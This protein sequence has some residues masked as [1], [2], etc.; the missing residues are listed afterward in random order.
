MNN[1]YILPLL[2]VMNIFMGIFIAYE[3][4]NIPVPVIKLIR[5]DD[6]DNC[7]VKQENVAPPTIRRPPTIVPREEQPESKK[8]SLKE[9]DDSEPKT[10]Y[11]K[12]VA[13]PAPIAQ[14]KPVQVNP[15]PTSQVD[16]TKVK[17]FAYYASNID[18]AKLLQSDYGLFIV[19]EANA[20]G[21]LWEKP[22]VDRMKSNGKIILADI[23]VTYAESQRW[24][25]DKSWSTKKPS[26]L[27][28]EYNKGQYFVNEWWSEEWWKITQGIIDKALE[29]GYNGI[30]LSGIDSYIELGGAKSL[31]DKMVD[32]V[33]AISE[34]AKG[35]NP[36]F[37]IVPK[38]AELLGRIPT[39]A[40]AID[41]MVK[42]DLVYSVVSN[43]STGPKNGYNQI[44]KSTG[45]LAE[46]KKFGKPVFVIEYVTGSAWTD[47]KKVIKANGFIG[48]SG[49]SRAPNAIRESVW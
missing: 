29:A 12:P 23:S 25:W 43:G 24:Y 27:G 30:V 33:I 39:Y 6:V 41:G 10:T 1:K 48:Y 46:F 13:Q 20:T 9:D 45:D 18:I 11:P 38:N 44:T 26:F 5:K 14:P 16:L 17:S 2:L 36:N 22:E 42:E 47:A 32:Y 19:N 40:A 7:E 15:S 37:L 4:F 49:N 8:Q 21:K 28:D 31:R 35:K 34:Y 3:K